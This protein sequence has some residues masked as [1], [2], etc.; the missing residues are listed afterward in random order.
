MKVVLILFF[1]LWSSTFS[2]A[3]VEFQRGERFIASSTRE[4]HP[5]GSTLPVTPKGRVTQRFCGVQNTHAETRRTGTWQTGQRDDRVDEE[6]TCRL[7]SS[8]STRRLTGVGLLS[9]ERTSRALAGPLPTRLGTPP[10]APLRQPMA[11]VSSERW[12]EHKMGR[13][14]PRRP[15]LCPGDH[16]GVF[17]AGAEV[18]GAVFWRRPKGVTQRSGGFRVAHATQSEKA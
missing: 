4:R 14:G 13:S 10:P 9:A 8:I 17:E 16:L 11:R 1:S 3:C 18:G 2:S 5:Q 12:V 7:G 6:A 15:S